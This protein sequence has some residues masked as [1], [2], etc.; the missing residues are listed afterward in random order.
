MK[1]RVGFFNFPGLGVTVRQQAGGTVGIVF[2]IARD[3]VLQVP[4]GSR[5]VTQV[6]FSNTAAIENIEQIGTR[7]D[8]LVITLPRACEVSLIR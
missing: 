5:K 1:E 3:D 2:R 4:D 7:G 6:D 8:R